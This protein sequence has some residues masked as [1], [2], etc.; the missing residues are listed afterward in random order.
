M[1]AFRPRWHHPSLS[2]M[3]GHVSE[4][5]ELIAA[6]APLLFSLLV[7]LTLLLTRPWGLVNQLPWLLQTKLHK[8]SSALPLR[9]KP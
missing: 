1:I 2:V 7:P 5:S 9:G 8:R 6:H 3:T 4:L